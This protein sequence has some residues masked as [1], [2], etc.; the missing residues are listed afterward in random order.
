MTWSLPDTYHSAGHGRGTATFKFYEGRDILFAAEPGSR[1][2][3]VFLHG[4]SLLPRGGDGRLGALGRLPGRD[5]HAPADLVQQQIQPSQEVAHAGP[6][7]HQFD[8]PGQR[9]A[10]VRRYRATCRS[11]ASP[12]STPP[13]LTGPLPPGPF[14]RGQLT[15]VRIWHSA[16]CASHH[17]L[18]TSGIEDR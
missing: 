9:P 2:A 18:A 17:E 13:R 8:D 15:T 3:A 1:S 12:R 10:L 11:L 14:L 4:P 16:R 6:A 7:A 5:L